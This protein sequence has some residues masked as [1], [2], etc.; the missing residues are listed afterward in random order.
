[1]PEKKKEPTTKE[2]RQLQDERATGEH[3]AIDQAATDDEAHQH[4]RRG[5]KAA[6][7]ARK[8][9]E[10]ERSERESDGR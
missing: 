4:E 1:M 5:D 6:Y 3:E 8:L 7:L 10:R 9:A 2:L